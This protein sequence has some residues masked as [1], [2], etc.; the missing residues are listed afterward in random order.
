MPRRQATR[1]RTRQTTAGRP[2]P[3]KTGTPHGVET[4]D[5]D[6][7]RL[8]IDPHKSLLACVSDGTLAVWDI[9]LAT[10]A[11]LAA[12]TLP[13]DVWA[14]SCAFVGT[15]GLIFGTFGTSCR[16]YDYLRDELLTVNIA[17]ING[18]S[19]CVCAATTSPAHD[20]PYPLRCRVP[21]SGIIA[22]GTDAG[23]IDPIPAGV[24]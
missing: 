20:V 17:P 12:T 24:R 21:T 4:R 23:H 6:V 2:L 3:S 11:P 19:E 8:L 5:T 10:P 15:S 14:R 9:S 7:D 16:T 18:N 1:R 13:D 22:V